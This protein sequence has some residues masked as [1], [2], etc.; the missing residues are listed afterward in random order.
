MAGAQQPQVSLNVDLWPNVRI[1]REGPSMF[2]W[3]DDAG[4]HSTVSVTLLTEVGF[5]AFV[6]QRIQRITDDTDNEL[7][8][9][10]YVED[11]GYWRVGKQILPFGLRSLEREFVRAARIDTTLAVGGWPVQ[12]AW[13]DGGNGKPTGFVGRIGGPIGLS[14]AHGDHFGIS[15]SAFNEV[16]R[17][18]DGLPLGAGQRQ[19]L[20]ADARQTIGRWELAAEWVRTRLGHTSAD[21][22]NDYVLLRATC[23][24]GGGQSVSMAWG[25]DVGLHEDSLRLRVA[26]DTGNG[27][28]FVPQVRWRAGEVFEGSIGLH[29]GL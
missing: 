17:P 20:G 4:H 8:N 23:S 7:L 11:T 27:V 24:L 19:L 6:S 13:C 1:A 21:A 10:Y 15:G 12:A 14:I 28:F 16:R 5:Q 29:V 9:E 22:D 26:I 2:R 25:R 3:Y 18:E